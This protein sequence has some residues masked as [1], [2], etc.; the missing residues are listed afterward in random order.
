MKR[1]PLNEKKNIHETNS[2][3]S[4]I[5]NLSARVGSLGDN[6]LGGWYS[7]RMSKAALNMATV[8]SAIELKRQ[9]TQVLSMH[10]GTNKTGLSAPFQKNVT[11]SKLFEAEYGVRKMMNVLHDLPQDVT[12]AFLAWDGSRIEW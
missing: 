9:R 10:P 12:G 1:P 8:N 4:L 11:P 5:C 6:K 7:Y 3:S 2:P